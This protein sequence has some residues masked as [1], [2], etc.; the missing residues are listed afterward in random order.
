MRTRALACMHLRDGGSR[1]GRWA[2]GMQTCIIPAVGQPA[3]RLH[4][5]THTLTPSGLTAGRP[6]DRT[7]ALA[8]CLLQPS[9]TP[10]RSPRPSF[11][12]NSL[13]WWRVRGAGGRAGEQHMATTCW[14]PR[15]VTCLLQQSL[16]YRPP[17][18]CT[19]HYTTEPCCTQ[20]GKNAKRCSCRQVLEGCALRLLLQGPAASSSGTSM[21][22]PCGG[23]WRS[24]PV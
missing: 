16:C 10:H 1:S 23:R 15:A 24:L 11:C 7:N 5:P 3:P 2:A 8:A 19:Q 14:P 12:S 13:W 17:L 4:L 9:P 20:L 22:G 6:S 18:L 21:S